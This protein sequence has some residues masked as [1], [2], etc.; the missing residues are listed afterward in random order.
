M[1]KTQGE[2]KPMTLKKPPG[3]GEEAWFA[4]FYVAGSQKARD[5]ILFGN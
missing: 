5:R 2:P 4:P 3:A 1:Q